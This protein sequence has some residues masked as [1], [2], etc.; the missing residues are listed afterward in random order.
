MLTGATYLSGTGAVSTDFKIF[1]ASVPI[2]KRG[3]SRKVG[4]GLQKKGLVLPSP[5]PTFV[6]SKFPS[7]AAI[8][9]Y[10]QGDLESAFAGLFH[11]L[12]KELRI[13]A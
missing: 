5:F 11:L 10:Y 2:C 1:V 3:F 4:S 7:L 12:T 8:D 6:Q 13:V 9:V